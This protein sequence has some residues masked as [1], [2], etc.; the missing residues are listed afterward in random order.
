MEKERS[1]NFIINHPI[2]R[3]Q[4]KAATSNSFPNNHQ[5]EES[6]IPSDLLNESSEYESS[7]IKKSTH[8]HPKS[9]SPK[10]RQASSSSKP[11]KQNTYHLLFEA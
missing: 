11:P 1:P 4:K 3:T 5:V 6:L 8:H 2:I 7:A 9:Q 10:K